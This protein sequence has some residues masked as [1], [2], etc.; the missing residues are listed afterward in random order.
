MRFLSFII[1]TMF[2]YSLI[3]APALIPRP[4]QLAAKSWLLMDAISGDIIVEHNI[5]KQLP[6]ASLTKMMTSYLAAH[7]MVL[8]NVQE[9][10]LARIS[11]KAWKTGGSKMFIREGTDVKAIDL[12]RGVIIQSGNDASVALS[13]FVA[14]S[15]DAFVDLMNQQAAI[16]GMDNTHYENVT[17]L[18]GKTHLTS[19]R[20]L[21]VLAQHIINDHPDYYGIYSE[22]EFTFNNIRQTNRNKLLWRDP[23]VDGL[24]TGHT[25]EAGFCLVASAIKDDMRLIAVVLG[26]RSENSRAQETQKL[27]TYG[28]RYFESHKLFTRLDVIKDSPLWMGIN[29]S[30]SL[31]AASDVVVN[32]PRGQYEQLDV[33]V[34]IDKVIKAPIKKGQA[35]GK[36]SVVLDGKTLVETPLVALEDEEEAGFFKRI[37]DSIVLFFNGLF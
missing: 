33:S 24:K 30:L 21:S 19:A 32:I 17:G 3:A 23:S 14:G 36:I 29:D 13:E 35:L 11:V 7:E 28:F 16:W 5:D 22:K 20:D 8:G 12:L 6:P 10:D 9:T 4:P 26:A 27:L 37:W 34:K 1:L 15:E 31:G 25:D 18:P 2:S